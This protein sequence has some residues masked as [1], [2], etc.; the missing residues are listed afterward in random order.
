MTYKEKNIMIY[1][2]QLDNNKSINKIINNN[3]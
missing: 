3:L 1:K 2:A